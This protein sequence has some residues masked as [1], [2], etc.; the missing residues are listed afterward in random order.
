MINIAICENEDCLLE[1]LSS[2]VISILKERGLE[3]TLHKFKS[4]E[5][6][7]TSYPNNLDIL[8]MDILLDGINGF[9]TITRVRVFDSEVNIIFTTI[10]TD[11]VY[12]AYELSVFRYLIKPI[13]RLKLERH[14]CTC[15]E[16]ILNRK[17]TLIL[18][19]KGKN[20]I[21]Y[22]KSIIYAEVNN[23]KITIV[24][25]DDKE[26]V[27]E[28]TMNQLEKQLKPHNFYRCHNSF[29][30]NLD[31]IET[32]TRTSVIV[33]KYEIPVS[34]TKTEGLNKEHLRYISGKLY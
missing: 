15:I 16:Q 18:T 22:I 10:E 34:R 7:L 17:S 28:M 13:N 12:D 30:I 26:L 19:T 2:L 4:G 20:H 5:D 25:T 14:L 33:N 8:F 31:F 1:E 24:L 3:F 11:Y 6:L 9:E 29:I 32:I 27:V 21:I 23:K